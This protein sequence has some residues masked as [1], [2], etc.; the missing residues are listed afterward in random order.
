MKDQ[1]RS[2]K[3]PA[4]QNIREQAPMKVEE[5]LHR[6]GISRFLFYQEVKRGRIHPKKCGARTMIPVEE[7]ERWLRELPDIDTSSNPQKG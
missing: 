3:N 1:T 2:T 5:F 4:D 7:A 6:V